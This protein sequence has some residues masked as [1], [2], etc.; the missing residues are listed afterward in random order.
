MNQAA[1]DG[2]IEG[3]PDG[4]FGPDKYITRAEAVTL[5]NRT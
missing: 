1:E 3:Y 4:T 2:F 5:V